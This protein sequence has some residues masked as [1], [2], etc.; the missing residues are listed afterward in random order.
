MVIGAGFGRKDHGSIPRNYDR[1]GLELLD[2][3][4]DPRIRLGDP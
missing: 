2:A 1:R 3:R 4:T